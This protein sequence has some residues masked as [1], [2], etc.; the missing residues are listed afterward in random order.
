[1]Q[2]KALKTFRNKEHGVPPDGLVRTGIVIT[3][4]DRIASQWIGLGLVKKWTGHVMEPELNASLPG[5][6]RMAEDDQCETQNSDTDQLDAGEVTR[7]SSPRRARPSRKK[8][9][10]SSKAARD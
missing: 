6:D 10:R 8:T 5:P 9:S 7:S 4:P 1:M 2:V 3:V